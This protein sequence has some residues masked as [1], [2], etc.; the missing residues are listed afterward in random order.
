MFFLSQFSCV[1]QKVVARLIG[2]SSKVAQQVASVIGS[3]TRRGL[4]IDIDRLRRDLTSR[5]DSWPFFYST[6]L[7][8]VA[9]MRTLLFP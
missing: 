6:A 7:T 8:H 1:W 4:D 5:P 3:E 9:R 2:R